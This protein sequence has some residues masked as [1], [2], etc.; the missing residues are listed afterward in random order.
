MSEGNSMSSSDRRRRR[1]LL[2]RRDGRACRFCGSSE[3][4]TID[5]V[6]PKSIGGTNDLRNLQLLCAD[7][8]AAKGSNRWGLV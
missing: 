5:H 2:I 6:I 7:C 8:N 4:L 1:K 3:N